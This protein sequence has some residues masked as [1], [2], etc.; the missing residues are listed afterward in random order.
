MKSSIR[1]IIVDDEKHCVEILEYELRA[2]PDIEIIEKCADG[3]E[4][5]TAIKMHKP[6]LVFLDIDMP[7]MNGFEVIRSLDE[8]D[9]EVIFVTA[10]DQ[11]ALKAFRYSALDYLLK[12]VDEEEL[13]EAMAKVNHKN[14]ST[15]HQ[16]Q[17]DLLLNSLSDK[18]PKNSK[19]IL[20]TQ[21][22][23]EFVHLDDIIRCQAESNYTHVYL[24]DGRH[25][26]MA[27]TLK[28]VEK[29]LEDSRFF[30]THQSHLIHLDK[31]KR[32][33][34]GEGGYIVMNDDSIVNV[35]RGKK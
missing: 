25:L 21:E 6:D 9:F 3:R 2:F 19:L 20:P 29:L 35:A 16:A 4:A 28:D 17:V 12:P 1:T 15:I 13:K 33:A 23:L 32:Y 24:E 18:M 22:G 7:F 31:I 27:K 26:M 10:F 5:I 30:R 14:K 11:F 8:I 34:R